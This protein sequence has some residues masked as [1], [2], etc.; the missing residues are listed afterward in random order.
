MNDEKSEKTWLRWL[1]AISPWVNRQIGWLYH[2]LMDR[3][4]WRA[5]FGRIKRFAAVMIYAI[6]F[7]TWL[8]GLIVL[9]SKLVVSVFPSSLNYVSFLPWT[10]LLLSKADPQEDLFSRVR[11]NMVIL[12]AWVGV[13]FLV[14]RT[15]IADKQTQINQES[16]YTDLFTKAVEQLGAVRE[17]QGKEPEPALEIRIGAIYSLERLAKDSERDYG[18]IIETLAAYI[19][20]HCCDPESFDADDLSGYELKQAQQKWIQS[21][22][23]NPPADRSDVAA[24]LTVLSRREQN[25]NW[26]STSENETQP[27]FTGANFQG[28][29]LWNKSEGLAREGT[30]LR[31][32]H[33]EGANLKDVNLSGAI[34]WGANLSGAILESANLSGANLVRADLSNAILGGTNLSGAGLVDANLS[35]AILVGADLSGEILEGANLS[36][37]DLVRADLSGAHLMGADLSNA[38]LEGANLSGAILGGANLLGADLVRA[39]LS[40]ARLAF[41]NLSGAVLLRANLSGAHLMGANLSDAILWGADLSGANLKDVD[42]S[43]AKNFEGT[44]LIGTQLKDSRGLMDEMLEKAFGDGD[45]SLPDG[46]TRPAHWGS[47][48]DA[49]EQWRA[50]REGR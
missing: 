44:L 1:R 34:L 33:L 27:D 35:S 12:T 48:E 24:V 5:R 26:I 45:I 22:R 38:R 16:H 47:R 7:V 6:V 32:A 3:R 19:R 2:T 46:L 18:P 21:L 29:T 17:V 39:D 31:L 25:R 11:L 9:S 41:A 13:F 10:D 14:W 37:A 15:R 30:N 42:L 4:F 36:G 49:I 23:E 43:G 8:L 20:E 40:N 28:A 50:F